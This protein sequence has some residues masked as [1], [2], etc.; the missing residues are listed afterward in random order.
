MNLGE[1]ELD[2]TTCDVMLVLHDDFDGEASSRELRQALDLD[3]T[4]SV[5]Y[6]VRKHLLDRNLVEEHDPGRDDTGRDL[7]LRY[8]M[9]ER[10]SRF[11]NTFR[12]DLMASNGDK[13]IEERVERL[14]TRVNQMAKTLRTLERGQQAG[15]SDA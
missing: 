12:E 5:K 10:G 14:E 2:Q 15:N 13:P 11:V 7:P 3:H 1:Q 9:T 6:R 4:R 8:E